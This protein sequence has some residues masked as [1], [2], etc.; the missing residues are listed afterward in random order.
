MTDFK[1]AVLAMAKARPDLT[2]TQLVDLA[3][4]VSIDEPDGP[5]NLDNAEALATWAAR[6]P[7]VAEAIAQNKKIFAIKELRALTGSS[8]LQ[9][10][11]AM[12]IAMPYQPREYY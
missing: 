7:A 5:P 9:A 1:T 8:L 12:D 4:A 11:N 2:V 6:Q 10:K 3:L